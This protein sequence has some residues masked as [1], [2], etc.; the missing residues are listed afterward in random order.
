MAADAPVAKTPRR[1]TSASFMVDVVG[2]RD[3]EM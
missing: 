2:C 1:E 3:V